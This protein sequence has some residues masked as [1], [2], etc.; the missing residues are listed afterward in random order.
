MDTFLL[1]ANA[2]VGVFIALR[3]MFVARGS[4]HKLC[5]KVI[6]YAG[7]L[8]AFSIPVR[9]WGAE[10]LCIDASEFILNLIVLIALV[11]IKGDLT[12]IV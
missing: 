7:T 1:Q 6:A 11:A 4:N 9:I 5:H 12:K 8:A 3:L 10:Y 2:V